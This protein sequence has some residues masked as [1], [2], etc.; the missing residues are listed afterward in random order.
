MGRWWR[1]ALLVPSSK[2]VVSFDGLRGPLVLSGSA[3]KGWELYRS[4]RLFRW[5]CV[6]CIG[7]ARIESA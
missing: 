2:H 3:G 1:V 7:R 6:V 4:K 5:I